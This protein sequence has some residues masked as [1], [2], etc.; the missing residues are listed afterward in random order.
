MRNW[1]TEKP[2]LMPLKKPSYC[3]LYIVDERFILFC[4]EF[5]CRHDDYHS[6]GPLVC[7]AAPC[8]AIGIIKLAAVVCSI[9]PPWFAGID[10]S[11][12]QSL[13]DTF[14]DTAP[15]NVHYLRDLFKAHFRYPTVLAGGDFSESIIPFIMEAANRVLDKT[16]LAMGTFGSSKALNLYC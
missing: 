3:S 6:R 13:I 4:G 5:E 12:N 15:E 11:L 1:R 9:F 10:P 7:R 8:W 14:S 2:T 16:S